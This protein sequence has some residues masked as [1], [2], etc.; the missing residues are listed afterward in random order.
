VT[1][2]LQSDIPGTR[3]DPLRQDDRIPVLLIQRSLA[4][5]S[6]D[7]EAIH[8]WTLIIPAGWSMAFFNSLIF[9][10][11]RV[12]GQLERQTQAYEAGTMYYPRDYPFTWAYDTYALDRESTDKGAWERKPPAKRVN[13]EALGTRSPWRADW[14]VVLGISTQDEEHI[15]PDPPTFVT[16]QR[17][18]VSETNVV[19]PNIKPWLLRG[20]EV[21]KILSSIFSVFNHGATVLLEINKLRLKRGLSPLSNDVKSD[22]LRGA[23]INVKISM[24]SR[25]APQDLAA[26]YSLSDDL[27][28]KWEK[29][30]LLRASGGISLEDDTPQEI[31]VS[32]WI[33]IEKST[34]MTNIFTV[35]IGNYS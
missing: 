34:I 22:L 21:P 31:E 23:L 24:C 27:Y 14:E 33:P 25:G 1:L 28:K 12:G 9:T 20:T 19:K 13:F 3:L 4:S 10:N 35:V 16:T 32:S 6:S 18:A 7:S 17:E 8:G 15:G 11:T 29:A 2:N 26:V 5:S 30:L